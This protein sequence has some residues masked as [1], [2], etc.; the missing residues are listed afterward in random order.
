MVSSDGSTVALLS[1]DQGG[2]VFVLTAGTGAVA[3]ATFPTGGQDLGLTST[4]ALLA[5]ASTNQLKLYS[6]ANGLQWIY[7]GDSYLRFPR[8]S[9]NNTRLVC[10][11]DLGTVDV[12][13]TS[14]GKLFERDM[15]ALCAAAWV[16]SGTYAGDLIL[17]SWEGAVYH[18][19]AGT[20][21]QHG[22]RCCSPPPPT[23]APAC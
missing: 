12:L 4:G 11:S 17:A 1:T 22:V 5:V 15:G 19:T 13:N 16:S 2:R 9:A 14:G 6:L 18:L 8:F 23:C 21:A 20:F 10:T 3:A 7:Q